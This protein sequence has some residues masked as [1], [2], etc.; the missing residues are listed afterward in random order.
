MTSVVKLQGGL[1]NQMFQF[2]FGC[3][4]NLASGEEVKYDVVGFKENPA[5]SLEL[6]K[7]FGIEL[8]IATREEIRSIKGFHI[9]WKNRDW[10]SSS[11]LAHMGVR[12]NVYREKEARFLPELLRQRNTY[13]EGYFQSFKFFEENAAQ[14]K[15]VFQFRELLPH[16]E[17]N[18]AGL[19]STSSS[20]GVHVRRGDYISHPI[21]GGVVG[22]AYYANAFKHILKT[23]SN[24]TFFIF[25]DDIS[26]CKDNLPTSSAKKVYVEQNSIDSYRD[27]QLM[28]LC[29][30]N[31]IANSSFSWW[32]AWLNKNPEKIV[33]AP[34]RWRVDSAIH[35]SDLLPNTWRRIPVVAE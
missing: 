22:K 25:S 33:C 30:H 4:A 19:I 8:P 2:A 32:A 7:A 35:M 21:L 27:M 18:I 10:P 29:K 26:W 12:R 24:P 6:E 16:T 23:V 5:R 11:F 34:T 13:F 14:I 20:V 3:A 31:I 17:E 1:G 15:R 9:R 28:H